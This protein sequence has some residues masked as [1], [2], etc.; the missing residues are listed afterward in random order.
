MM[1]VGYSPRW[2]YIINMS[3]FIAIQISGMIVSCHSTIRMT[4]EKS[5]LLGVLG[6]TPQLRIVDFL[7]GHYRYDYSKKEIAEGAGIA[8]STLYGVWKE[9]EELEIVIQTRAYGNT[10]LF[11][12]NSQNSLVKSLAKMDMDLVELTAPKKRIIADPS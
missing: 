5:L 1:G 10:R 12:I 9:L 4:H 6:D 8:V 11:K 3:N 2:D 7:L